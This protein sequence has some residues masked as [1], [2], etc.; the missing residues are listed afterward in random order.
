MTQ[1]I[2]SARISWTPASWRG[3]SAAQLPDY[4][5]SAALTEVEERLAASLPLVFAGEIRALR[6]QL[7]EV[8]VGRAFLLQGGDCAESFAQFNEPAITDTFRVLLQMAVVLTFAAACPVVK[9]GRM[10]GQF[11]KPRSSPTETQDG[12]VLPSYRGD[13]VNGLDFTE[14]A[15]RPE[16]RRQLRAYA[17]SAATLN[18][19]RALAQGGFADLHRVQQWNLDFLHT[20]PLG[21][22]YQE[23]AGRISETLAFMRAC[24]LDAATDP[25]VRQVQFYTSHEALLLNYEQALTRRDSTTGAWYSGSAHFLWIGERTRQLD[26]A[27]VEFARG[28]ANPIGVKLGPTTDSD[29]LLRLLDALNPTDQPG[30]LT[31]ISRMGADRIETALP[32]LIRAVQREGRQVVWSCDPMHGNTLATR[33]GYKTRPFARILDEVRGFF[34]IHRAEGSIPGGMHFELTGQDVTECLGGSQAI[35]E[36]GLADRYHTQCDPRL[37]ALQ[38][39]ELAFLIA[40]TLKDYRRATQRD[41]KVENGGRDT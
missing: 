18:L 34:A 29:T 13:I 7:A 14:A 19:L 17:Q 41:H 5:D 35:T 8:A 3:K 21:A 31:L 26:G 27:H 39:L 40:E 15:R 32:P 9:V 12:R 22:R 33:T 37:N 20:N 6:E 28:I 36:E 1:Y 4:P 30:R 11:A 38:S 25:Q 23:L 24:R 10:A 2:P 16:P